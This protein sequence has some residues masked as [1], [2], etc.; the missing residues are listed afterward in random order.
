M[1]EQRVTTSIV[2]KRRRARVLA[3]TRTPAAFAV[4]LFATSAMATGETGPTGPTRAKGP[5]GA[6]GAT[7]AAGKEGSK[8]ATGATG[9]TGKEG[10]GASKGATGATGATGKEGK[11]GKEGKASSGPSPETCAESE[12]KASEKQTACL[13]K[14]GGT[15]TGT[16]GATINV[17]DGGPQEQAYGVISLPIPY[18]EEPASE[19]VTVRDESESLSPKDPC[20]GEVNDPTAEKGNLCIYTGSGLPH[21]TTDKDAKYT[22]ITNPFGE[23]SLPLGQKRENSTKKQTTAGWVP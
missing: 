9:A 8:G 6:T 22:G 3:L 21:E 14:E 19:T 17:S 16:W 15:E 12:P 11:E 10:K 7:G 1:A 2:P 5:T 23:Q 20:V 13:L 18:P 4:L